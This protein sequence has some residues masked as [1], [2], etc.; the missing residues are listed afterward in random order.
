MRSIRG[1]PAVEDR[2]ADQE[3]AERAD[4]QQREQRRQLE[5][6]VAGRERGRAEAGGEVGDRRG[7]AAAPCARPGR[8]IRA[9]CCQPGRSSRSSIQ[10]RTFARASGLRRRW[11]SATI[12][13]ITTTSVPNAN[14]PRE[15]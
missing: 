10:S 2:V 12:P 5:A 9:T 7:R 4:G 3:E 6:E 8:A 14:S 11:I 13:P 15:T 1:S